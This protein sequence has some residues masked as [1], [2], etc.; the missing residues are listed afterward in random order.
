ME[1]IR[2]RKVAS[3]DQTA[4][5]HCS[6]QPLWDNIRVPSI[7]AQL[8]NTICVRD[9]SGDWACITIEQTDSPSCPAA[10]HPN[11]SMVSAA[12]PCA[13]AI[14]VRCSC[15]SSSGHE[16]FCPLAAGALRSLTGNTPSKVFFLPLLPRVSCAQNL[17][18][19]TTFA[20]SGFAT[21]CGDTADAVGPSY[22]RNDL[23]EP[24]DLA[25][26]KR[27]H[28][29]HRADYSGTSGSHSAQRNP[30][31][32]DTGVLV[33][34]FMISRTRVALSNRCWTPC[35]PVKS[36]LMTRVGFLASGFAKTYAS[37]CPRC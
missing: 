17:V 18:V 16:V 8:G 36:S 7:A 24:G 32:G 1:T 35:F 34:A 28:L 6:L 5:V 12:P 3:Q 14:K 25:D 19:N 2:A 27:R 22:P 9:T 26:A 20:E 29:L 37:V 21:R 31:Q 15:R 30:A 33:P 13:T 10:N 23:D 11:S 4:Q